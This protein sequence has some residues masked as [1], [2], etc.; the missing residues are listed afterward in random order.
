MR[1]IAPA[2]KEDK[3]GWAGTQEGE[4]GLGRVLEVL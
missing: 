2:A 1:A 4:E 3:P